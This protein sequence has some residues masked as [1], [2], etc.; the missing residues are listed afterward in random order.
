MAS[1]RI[2]S[3]SSIEDELESLK[4]Q[5]DKLAPSDA[6]RSRALLQILEAC[7]SLDKTTGEATY[8][9]ERIEYSS[10]AINLTPE[11]DQA[12]GKILL[13]LAML[14]AIR[15]SESRTAMDV[16][17][18]IELQRQA[19][20]RGSFSNAEMEDVYDQLA[21]TLVTKY[22]FDNHPTQTLTRPLIYTLTL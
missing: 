18:A 16:E 9:D 17:R 22:S 15:G 7:Q 1:K 10:A 8:L 20:V 21:A 11:G 4:A 5:I 13:G 14:Y 6:D 3:A 12:W 19:V 2:E